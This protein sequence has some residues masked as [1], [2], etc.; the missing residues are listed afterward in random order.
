MVGK[1]CRRGRNVAGKSIA[2]IKL[3]LD[4]DGGFRIGLVLGI[5]ECGRIVFE[6]HYHGLVTV[7]K[8]MSHLSVNGCG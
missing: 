3:F 4:S 7:L 6:E 1:N 5:G 8:M 2:V